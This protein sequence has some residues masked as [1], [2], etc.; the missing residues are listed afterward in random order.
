LPPTIALI[1][2][3]CFV[4]CLLWLERRQ[5]AHVTRASWI[6][7]IWMLYTASKPLAVWFPTSEATLES[8]PVD[9]GFLIALILITLGILLH[10][11]FRWW[12]AVEGNPAVMIYLGLMLVSIFWSSLPNTSFSRWVR[13]FQAVLM[14]FA[15]LSEP[16]P[17]RTVES[18]LRR[19][20]YILVPFSILLIKYFPDYGIEYIRW[21]GE[22]M[23]IGVAQQ[24]NSLG[25]LCAISAM[26]LIWSLVRRRRE[27]QAPVWKFE[28]PTECFLLALTAWVMRGPGGN[29]FYSATAF[30]ALSAALLTFGGLLLAKRSGRSVSAQA[31][32]AV[33]S[34]IMAFGIV[35]LFT[36]GSH[37]RFAASA[38]GR[39][40]TLTGRADVWASLLPA[41]MRHPLLGNG[42][43]GFWTPASR[44]VFHISGAHSGYLD[45]L[46][47]LGFSGL[48]AVGAF[49][50]SS[51]RRAH[52]ELSHDFDWGV[53]WLCFLV[54]AVLHN[55]AE[56]SIDSLTSF[57]TA[58][59][60]F[61]MVSSTVLSLEPETE[62]AR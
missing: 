1:G 48:L 45:V 12:A 16:S 50:L 42:F 14:A 17:R 31:T 53:L 61:M 21:T 56:S 28:V 8:S 39:D 23:W 13:E 54:M 58:V 43:G 24:K 15:V 26:F 47:G 60:L 55:T 32:M 37:I 4:L 9:R 30:Y 18:I 22:R 19:T 40:T 33:V 10:R 41:A 49:V 44:E 20:I 2:C 59:I 38:A 25:L 62:I 34:A 3:V 46:L 11:R 51:C 57:L 5:S 36:G 35:I 29:F 52:R 27:R 7:T 6:P